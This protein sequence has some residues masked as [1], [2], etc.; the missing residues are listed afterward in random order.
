MPK[1]T[2]FGMPDNPDPHEQLRQQ[3]IACAERQNGYDISNRVRTAS[4]DILQRMKNKP[5]DMM[6]AILDEWHL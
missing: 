1:E 5:L 2:E 4:V 6:R 3:V